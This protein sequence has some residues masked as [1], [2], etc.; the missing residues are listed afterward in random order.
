MPE[1]WL[2]VPQGAC[3]SGETVGLD[4]DESR[5]AARVLRLRVGDPVV[6]ADGC[7][8]V[9]K[10]IMSVV[11]NRRS[12]VEVVEV[13]QDPRPPTGV[14]LALAVLHSQAM[15]WAVQKAVEV[16]VRELVP[17]RS[18]RTQL[19]PDAV[20]ARVGHWRRVA[21]QA[22]KQCHRSWEMVVADP[23]ET[24]KLVE[25]R[26]DDRGLAAD[27]NGDLLDE[28][29]GNLPSLLLV[30]PEGGFS[31][32]EERVLTERGWPRVRLGPHVLRAETAAVVG[33]AMLVNRGSGFGDRD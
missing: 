3:R 29:A 6:L 19:S 13:R 27:R 32:T 26:G 7:G 17:V 18:E 33:A 21:R 14:T 23:I 30:G 20:G 9:A 24:S 5:H 15:D 16:G 10:G 22:V 31:Q 8:T 4:G 1:S 12:E 2:L 11:D 28:L 25:R